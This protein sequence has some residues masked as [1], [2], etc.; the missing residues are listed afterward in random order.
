MT[1]NC[2]IHLKWNENWIISYRIKTRFPA[3]STF[4]TLNLFKAIFASWNLRKI[5]NSS[6]L[7]SYKHRTRKIITLHSIECYCQCHPNVISVHINILGMS[8]EQRHLLDFT[9]LE[10]AF[11]WEASW[12]HHFNLFQFVHRQK[13]LNRWF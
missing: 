5:F 1:W 11:Q 8:G 7:F 6:T 10:L 2:V 3:T 13:S 9:E 12:K 4:S